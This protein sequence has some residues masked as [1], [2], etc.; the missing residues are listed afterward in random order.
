[1]NLS[2][3]RE[4]IRVKTGYPE[5]GNAGTLRI[6]NVLNQ[7]LRKLWGEIP[8][9]LLREEHRIELE[10]PRTFTV[11][12][13]V[14]VSTERRVLTVHSSSTPFTAAEALSKVLSARCIEWQFGDRWYHRKITE[15]IFSAGAHKIVVDEPISTDIASSST[16]M[17]ANIYTYEYPYDADLQSIKR[18]VKNPE[19]NPREVPLSRFGGEMASLRIGDGWQAKGDILYYQRGDFYQLEPPHY[20]P[21]SSLVTTNTGSI[22]TKWGFDS[23]STEQPE[24]GPAGTFSY[25]VCHVWGRL[26]NTMGEIKYGTS[27][28]SYPFYIS[29]PSTASAEV[30]T[31]WNGPAINVKTPNV[32]YVYG[33]GHDADS[34]AYKRCGIE[35]WVFRARNK[36]EEQPTKSSG[37]IHGD[38]VEADGVYYLWAV[39]DAATTEI[40]DN[41]IYDPVARRYSL[42]D[43]VGHN[44]I[45]FDKRPTS[46][47]QILMSCIRRPTTLK[48]DTDAPRIPPECYNALVELSCS[49]LV[50][51]R[52]GDIKRKSIYYEAYMLELSK[53]KRLYTFSGHERPSFGNG[54]KTSSTVRIGDYPV[55]ETS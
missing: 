40:Q 14:S 7:A 19:T 54:I 21:T 20:K 26:P 51:D 33:Y 2:E 50:G 30:S 34:P 27:K 24:Y 11:V 17:T 38:D 35:K 48:Y 22:V 29:S 36:V 16:Y 25:K 37:S 3:L 32:D 52:D 15:V 10:P 53:L 41:G 49:Y 43:F 46:A 47:D 18:I 5:R 4:A 55:T 31:T 1:M 12:L 39:L 6:N 44:H 45:R 8:E 28:V 23:S 42:K 9:V 13:D